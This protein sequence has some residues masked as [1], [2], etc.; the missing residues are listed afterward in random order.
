[1]RNIILYYRMTFSSN[2]WLIY[3][4]KIIAPVDV[5]STT[6]TMTINVN[7]KQTTWLIWTVSVN[8]TSDIGALQQLVYFLVPLKKI[9]EITSCW[10][11]GVV[12]GLPALKLLIVP[13]HDPLRHVHTLPHFLS[14]CV[15]PPP[16]V[17]GGPARA[18]SGPARPAGLDT[19]RSGP[20][21]RPGTPAGPAPLAW[22]AWCDLVP[23]AWVTS[24]RHERCMH[25][26]VHT[27]Q[28]GRVGALRLCA[29]CA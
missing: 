21:C 25:C 18:S 7:V 27:R 4:H 29:G 17:R 16:H 28:P 8:M 12:L 20:P 14:K 13:C 1:L 9:A 2:A 10:I 19:C 24:D 6:F 26:T 3:D 11:W 5:S 15:P 22:L 23:E